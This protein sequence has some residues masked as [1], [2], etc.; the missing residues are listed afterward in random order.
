LRILVAN[1]LYPPAAVGGY[2]VECQGVVE[3]L[4]EAHD[5]TVLTSSEGRDRAAA[6]PGVRRV[7]PF[8]RY[9]KRDSVRAPVDAVRGARQA[10]AALDAARPDVV[11]IWNGAQIPQAALHVLTTSGAPVL[12]RI[13]QQWFGALYGEDVF[14]RHLRPGERGP[15]G[16]W[17]AGMRAVNRLPPLRI[18]PDRRVPGAIAWVSHALRDLT[19]VPAAVEPVHEEVLYAATPHGDRFAEIERRPAADTTIA[20]VGRLEPAKGAD[21]VLRA[22]ALLGERHGVEARLVLAGPGSDGDRARLG[23]LAA[24]LGVAGRV[25]LPGPLDFPALA[26]LLGGAAAWVIPSVWDEPAPLVCT[27]AALA[28]VPAVLSRVGGIPEMLH[29]GEHALFFE[30]SDH[31]GCAD[32][33]AET[34]G[35]PEA[36]AA[37]VERAH[38]RGRELM[39]APY[40]AAMDR[41][42]EVSLAAL[43]RPLSA[44]GSTRSP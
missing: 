37:R 40:L 4:R 22:L 35:D 13:C 32:R 19:P 5:V 21:V 10:R 31:D 20:F 16:A 27:E 39:H 43:G 36:T 26:E 29:D 44:R 17:A 12:W 2:E 11:W 42:L 18:D 1:N 28:R 38:A 14:A 24:Q 23:T 6:V 7:L 9:R 3:H 30:R 41:F 8:M 15:R 25:T 33:L 34:L